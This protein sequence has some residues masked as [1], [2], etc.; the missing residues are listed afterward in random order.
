MNKRHSILKKN[1]NKCN[2]KMPE[3]KIIFHFSDNT[4]KLNGG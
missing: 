2:F 1:L 3:T 4:R